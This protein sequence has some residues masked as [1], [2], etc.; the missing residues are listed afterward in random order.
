MA[1]CEVVVKLDIRL[2]L[3]VTGAVEGGP[4]G[5]G[6][7][8]FEDGN[9]WAKGMVC[10]MTNGKAK[11]RAAGRAR[12]RAMAWGAAGHTGALDG[13]KAAANVKGFIAFFGQRM[14]FGLSLVA[15]TGGVLSVGKGLGSFGWLGLSGVG[16][17]GH[18]FWVTEGV[19]G[20]V[21]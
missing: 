2:L 20:L 5:G 18:E 7:T 11:G 15:G 1:I 3:G 12:G 8:A 10:C 19:R 4:V 9:G 21:S 13:L 6:A 17:V 16:G 14:G